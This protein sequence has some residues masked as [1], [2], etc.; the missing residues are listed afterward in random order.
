MNQ[1][2]IEGPR[3]RK[4]EITDATREKEPAVNPKQEE[5][6]AELT[7]EIESCFE[8]LPQAEMKYSIT[9]SK[10]SGYFEV[11]ISLENP[12][13][14]FF[15][16]K[17]LR[18]NTQRRLELVVKNAGGSI[19]SIGSSRQTLSFSYKAAEMPSSKEQEKDVPSK[20]LDETP[21]P[22]LDPDG[23][24]IGE[25]P[26]EVKI[27]VVG[28]PSKE[29]PKPLTDSSGKSFVEDNPPATAREKFTPESTVKAER[30]GKKESVIDPEAK[31][32][33][34]K[35]KVRDLNEKYLSA[36]QR[37]EKTILYNQLEQAQREYR[38]AEEEMDTRPRTSE[39]ERKIAKLNALR[40]VIRDL[41]ERYLREPQREQKAILWNQLEAAQKEYRKLEE[42]L[43]TM[44]E[45]G[46]KKSEPVPPIGPAGPWNGETPPNAEGKKTPEEVSA[47][48]K[49]TLLLIEIRNGNLASINLLIAFINNQDE[50]RIEWL[51]AEEIRFQRTLIVLLENAQG[52]D[53][54][55]INVLIL[56]IT[57]QHVWIITGPGSPPP[58]PPTPVTGLPLTD[59]R[60]MYL[61]AKRKRGNVFRGFMGRLF[62]RTFNF[63]G[64]NMDFGGQQGAVD[65]ERVRMEYQEGLSRYRTLELQTLQADLQT[66]ILGGLITPAMANAEMQ[67]R[68]MELLS[69]EQGNI[70]RRSVQGIEQN[71]LEKMKTKWRQFART[72]LVTGG[73]LG[74][75][76]LAGSL[77]VTALSGGTVA[78]IGILG[79]RTV[80]GGVGTYV[81]VEAGLER[82]SRLIGHKNGLVR[83]ISGE[84]RNFVTPHARDMYMA[85]IPAAEIRQEA[86]RLRMLQVEKGV[87]INNLRTL[88][89]DGV[90]AAE[91]IRRDNELTAEEAMN[92]AHLA[93]PALGFAGMLSNR[94]AMEVNARN[95][96]VESE[97]DRERLKKMARKTTAALAGGAVGWLIGG[98]LFQNPDLGIPTPPPAPPGLPPSPGFPTPP[99][100]SFHTVTAGENT[101]KIIEAN[102]NAHNSMAGLVPGEQT[103]M[104]DALK[105]QLN[106]LPS[107]TL[108]SLGW[109]SGDINIINPGDVLDMSSIENTH[110]VLSAF[111]NAQ[112][113]SPAEITSIVENNN[114]IASWLATHRSELTGPLNSSIIDEILRG[115]R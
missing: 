54:A 70:D 112:N 40:E 68:M 33:I 61:N 97:V 81:G 71:I 80:M 49:F 20:P 76:A 28:A 47:R 113:L 100:P 32:K 115:T 35:E 103:H 64:T 67:G 36:T 6:R 108:R 78:G 72:R 22:L 55:A 87:S 110:N 89:D 92:T 95:E 14:F 39:R 25:T 90:I 44:G 65:L 114:K 102:L 57:T 99:I 43:D 27:D 34:L 3:G 5:L 13:G 56:F 85:A 7:R 8:G 60:D 16:D 88:G 107:S 51:T 37:E 45:D 23:K 75:A 4:I 31:L 41:N 52:G 15:G 109:S 21:K 83:R 18:E 42:E 94:L 48:K 106:N 29:T 17:K 86:A 104:I 79:A 77:G 69:E 58:A 30:K 74:G 84:A 82:Y 2:D 9:P 66:R 101:W 73:L 1:K 19:G 111:S 96:L 53:P 24:P 10:R 26:K 98:K 38:K 11:S 105:D 62:G 91:I 12:E 93:N 50:W 63:R 46:K 59:L